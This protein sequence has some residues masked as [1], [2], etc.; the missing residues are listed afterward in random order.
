MADF[1]KDSVEYRNNGHYV[2]DGKEFMSVQTFK[3]N[4][5][6]TSAN[7]TSINGDDGKLL[8]QKCSVVYSSKPDFGG[9]NEILIFPLDEL[10]EYYNVQQYSSHTWILTWSS[11]NFTLLLYSFF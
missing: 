6:G 10:K 5:R 2:I 11:I 8:A 3:N 1:S 4:H 9:F 7:T